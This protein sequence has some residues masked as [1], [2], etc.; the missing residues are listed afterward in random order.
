MTGLKADVVN[1]DD[2][3]SDSCMHEWTPTTK[4]S[5]FSHYNNHKNVT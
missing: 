4:H 1:I 3:F 5:K 2:F